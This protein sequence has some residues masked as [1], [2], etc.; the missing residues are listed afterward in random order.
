MIMQEISQTIDPIPS[1]IEYI[2]S[3]AISSQLVQ[4]FYITDGI[5]ETAKSN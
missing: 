4:Q 2:T 3:D 1:T 5:E